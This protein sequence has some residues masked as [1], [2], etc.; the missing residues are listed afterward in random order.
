[1]TTQVTDSSWMKAGLLVYIPNAGTFTCV[2]GAPNSL[3]VNLVN[4]G[5]PANAPVGTLI[6]AGAMVSPANLRGPTGGQGPQGPQGPPGPQ[7]VS[8]SSAYTTLAQAFT[9]PT[10]NGTAFVVAADAF[11]AG[12]VVFMAG[13]VGG[14]YFSIQSVDL[15]ANSLNL[16]NLNYAGAEPPGT[17]IPTGAI[18]SGTGPRGAQG[19]VGPAGPAGPQGVPGSD[20]PGTIKMYGAAS[21]PAGWVACNGA[22]LSRTSFPALFAA[23]STTWGAGDGSTTF[24]VPDFRGRFP[25]GQS[26]SFPIAVTGGEATHALIVAELAAHA[27]QLTDPGH[28]HTVPTGALGSGGVAAAVA[29]AGLVTTSSSQANITM[30]NTGSGTPHNN[31]PPYL[32]VQFIIKT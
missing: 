17:V 25:L 32:A 9:V 11:A 24:N 31:M 20:L 28:T 7:G 21:P 6:G 26:N 16:L 23:I 13:P 30:A 18:V 3:H 14:N 15:T 8:G 22:A 1:V 10:T 2:G 4:S 19:A 29:G 12:L 5:D 27:H